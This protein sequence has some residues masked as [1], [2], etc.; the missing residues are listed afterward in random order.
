SW[1]P[2]ETLSDATIAEPNATPLV[3]TAY[4]VT[5]K[6]QNGCVGTGTIEVNV[7]GDYITNKLTPSKFFSPGNG[8]EIGNFWLVD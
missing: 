4:V 7:K 2:S 6:D 8:D 3:T 1:T 5:G